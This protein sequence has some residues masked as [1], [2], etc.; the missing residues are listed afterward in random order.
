M[1]VPLTRLNS[2]HRYSGTGLLNPEGL[3][4]R[5]GVR[6]RP[7]LVGKRAGGRGILHV[8]ERAVP[9]VRG[10]RRIRQALGAVRVGLGTRDLW[11]RDRVTGSGEKGCVQGTA[12]EYA[13]HTY[14]RFRLQTLGFTWG[15]LVGIIGLILKVQWSPIRDK[16]KARLEGIWRIHRRGM[17]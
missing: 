3:G 1:S 12:W 4:G 6:E 14:A 15:S 2:L 5:K 13:P 17:F 11:R 10:V 9:R 7:Q 16:P 8:A